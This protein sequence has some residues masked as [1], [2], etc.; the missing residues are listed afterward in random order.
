MET[1]EDKVILLRFL[2]TILGVVAIMGK[3]LVAGGAATLL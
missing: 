3:V 1:A 2:Q